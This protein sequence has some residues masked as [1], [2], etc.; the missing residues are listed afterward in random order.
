HLRRR[1]DGRPPT[2]RR[3][4]DRSTRARHQN[5]RKLHARRD[6]LRAIDRKVPEIAVEKHTVGFG[7]TALGVAEHLVQA[8]HRHARLALN[9]GEEFGNVAVSG[10]VAVERHAAIGERAPEELAPVLALN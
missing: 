2:S 3:Y 8:D 4:S 6:E 7:L 5:L 10:A 9:L 1:P